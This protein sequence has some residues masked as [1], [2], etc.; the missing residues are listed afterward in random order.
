MRIESYVQ[1]CIFNIFVR[2]SGGGGGSGSGSLFVEVWTQIKYI[3][4][5]CQL[6]AKH[7][8]PPPIISF[9][10]CHNRSYHSVSYSKK[11]KCRLWLQ[12]L[13]FFPLQQPDF[14]GFSNDEV[15]MSLMHRST[16][17]ICNQNAIK[18]ITYN[19][20]SQQNQISVSVYH[21][22]RYLNGVYLPP[23]RF[24]LLKTNI[25]VK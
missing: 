12:F 13:I 3:Y 14:R 1:C 7:V 6:Y 11:K 5:H 4:I 10:I 23:E 25:H 20:Q 16:T 19:E 15:A 8:L 2:E 21:E 17:E 18:A 9:G 22:L 24:I